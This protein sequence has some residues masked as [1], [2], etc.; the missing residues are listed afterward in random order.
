[1]FGGP[2]STRDEISGVSHEY[3]QR[4]RLLTFEYQG[5]KITYSHALNKLT[6]DGHDFSTADGQVRILIKANGEVERVGR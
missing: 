4:R 5:H 6:V 1:L 2:E 3:S